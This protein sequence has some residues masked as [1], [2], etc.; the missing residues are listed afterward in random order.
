MTFR[1]LSAILSLALFETD[2]HGGIAQLARALGSYPGCHWF[3]SSC[4][5][6]LQTTDPLG[7][8]SIL[9]KRPGGQ[10][11]KTPPFHGG[12]TGSSPVR[13]TTSFLAV[14]SIWR[15]SSAGRASASHAEGHRF[16]FCCLHQ[17][18]P[19]Q[20][21]WFF[22]CLII[23]PDHIPFP[24]PKKIANGRLQLQ[25][26]VGYMSSFL[27]RRNMAATPLSYPAQSEAL[28]ICFMAFSLPTKSWLR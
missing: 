20:L 14:S 28:R 19:R 25:T 8:D 26:P 27:G 10:A 15:H 12:N 22:L 3:K 11:V 2:R 24:F 18:K 9:K 21:T 16:E 13:V 7:S 17:K 5:Y 1:G 4:R 6:H 23:V